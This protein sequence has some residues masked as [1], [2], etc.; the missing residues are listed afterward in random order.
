MVLVLASCVVLFVT[1]GRGT[2]LAVSDTVLFATELEA[3]LSPT[4]ELGAIRLEELEEL[5]KHFF[6]RCS[7][8]AVM[9]ALEI[10]RG[11][12]SDSLFPKGCGW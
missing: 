7:F 1:V 3:R 9:V 4:L 11:A 6:W 5:D 8:T 12:L 10:G 2:L